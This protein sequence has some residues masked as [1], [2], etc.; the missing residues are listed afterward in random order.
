M[1]AVLVLVQSMVQSKEE[2]ALNAAGQYTIDNLI[3]RLGDETA[4]G[5]VNLAP[6]PETTA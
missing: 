3:L 2:R 1:S 5:Y 6:S 4:R